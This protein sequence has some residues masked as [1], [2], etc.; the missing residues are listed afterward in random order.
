MLRAGS[1]LTRFGAIAGP[2]PA[3]S[4]SLPGRRSREGEQSR[5]PRATPW[6]SR[7]QTRS[8]PDSRMRRCQLCRR[9]RMWCQ[10]LPAQQNVGFRLSGLIRHRERM[11]SGSRERLGAETERGRATG[12]QEGSVG[13]RELD[14]PPGLC[15]S[16]MRL[17]EL[18]RKRRGWR[19]TGRIS[20]GSG[21]SAP[22]TGRADGYQMATHAL[23]RSE[24]G[25]RQLAGRLLF[26]THV[27]P[28]LVRSDVGAVVLRP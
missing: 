17:A 27:S 6:G 10:R 24:A 21:A 14:R 26:A 18:R 2:G 11:S 9:G 3:W 16:A 13:T 25:W 7:T 1:W 19:A 23:M 4:G 12:R 5:A 28:D 15:P 22:L 20:S 8:R